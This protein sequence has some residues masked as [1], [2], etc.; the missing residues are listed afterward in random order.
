MINVR[1]EILNLF[2]FYFLI[3]YSFIAPWFIMV[4]LWGFLLIESI[5]GPTSRWI[6][7]TWRNDPWF[8]SFVFF[9]TGRAA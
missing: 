9:L 3:F 1:A 7:R 8:R 2:G 6:R 5:Y 4:F